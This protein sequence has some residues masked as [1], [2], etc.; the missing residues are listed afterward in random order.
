MKAALCPQRREEEKDVGKGAA[1]EN[2]VCPNSLKGA[3]FL[4]VR[5]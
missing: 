2:E 1:R 3:C 5:E 4:Y